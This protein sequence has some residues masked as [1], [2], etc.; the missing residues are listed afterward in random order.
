MKKLL[1]ALMVIGSFSVYAETCTVKVYVDIAS[2]FE[3]TP[4][5]AI[6]PTLFAKTTQNL[7]LTDCMLLGAT[8]KKET[9]IPTTPIYYVYRYVKIEFA[10]TEGVLK[11]T[12]K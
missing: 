8:T 2:E 1:L 10:G 9:V 11:A 6:F 7:G 4:H 3:Q 12:L 5:Q